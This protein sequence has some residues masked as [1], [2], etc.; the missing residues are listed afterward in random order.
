LLDVVPE[1]GFW[2]EEVAGAFY[3]LEFGFVAHGRSP[4]EIPRLRRPPRS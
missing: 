2:G 1:G 3:G 4:G